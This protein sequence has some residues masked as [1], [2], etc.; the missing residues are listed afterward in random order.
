MEEFRWERMELV[1][2]LMFT[3]LASLKMDQPTRCGMAATM[4]QLSVFTMPLRRTG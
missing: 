4:D 1:T 3:V 2:T